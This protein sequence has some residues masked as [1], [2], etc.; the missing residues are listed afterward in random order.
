MSEVNRIY[1]E[2]MSNEISSIRLATLA[3]PISNLQ[4]PAQAEGLVT[5][6]LTIAIVFTVGD[7]EKIRAGT[8]TLEDKL[9]DQL[10]AVQVPSIIFFC[11]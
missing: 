7:L 1:T 2:K 6:F 4:N 11:C 10:A 5:S 3:V 8:T 9:G